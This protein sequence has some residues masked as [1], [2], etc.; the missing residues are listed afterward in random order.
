MQDYTEW[1]AKL[2]VLGV[3]EERVRAYD[4]RAKWIAMINPYPNGDVIAYFRQLALDILTRGEPMPETPEAAVEAESN[5]ELVQFLD[6]EQ[7]A[8]EAAEQLRKRFTID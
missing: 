4:E 6:P 7:F 5:R 2:A 1:R 8:Q 3:G